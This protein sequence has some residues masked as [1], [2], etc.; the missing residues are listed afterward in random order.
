MD[1]QQLLD[2]AMNAI[3]AEAEQSQTWEDSCSMTGDDYKACMFCGS[4][5]S[6]NPNVP[7]VHEKDCVY[8]DA[9]AYLTN[10]KH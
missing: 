2:K 5:N 6:K 8:L 9:V 1:N 7:V 3:L 4:H 10:P